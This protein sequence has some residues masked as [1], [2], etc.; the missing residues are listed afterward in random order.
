VA[1]GPDAS[2]NSSFDAFVAKVRADGT[3][4]VYCGY[5]G[6]SGSDGGFS[7]AVDGA[8]NAYVTGFTFS[9][10]F[11]VVVGPDTSFNGVADAFVAK[12][13]R[14]GTGLDY[15]GY[16]GGSGQDVGQGIAVD[17]A[18]NAYVTGETGSSDFPVAVG[19]DASLNSSI[20]AFVAKVAPPRLSPREAIG[21][22]IDQVEALVAAGNLKAG[23]GEALINKLE[24]AIKQLDRGHIKQAINQ[25]ES[26]IRRVDHLIEKGELAPAEG[27]SLI[28]A[29]NDI[30]AE[31]ER[32]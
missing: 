30:I 18:G 28:R 17:G 10:D 11:P 12:V 22:L 13:R 6:G 29:A 8:G 5:I 23:Q 16:I 24:M 15:C 26:F 7:I 3:G 32:Q 20:D 19:P 25:L 2:L 31:L 4:L 14:D 9:S 27:Q 1:V 21:Q